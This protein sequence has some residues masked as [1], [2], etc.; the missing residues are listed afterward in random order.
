MISMISIR[1]WNMLEKH[2]KFGRRNERNKFRD[3]SSWK[4][5]V[6]ERRYNWRNQRVSIK[7]FVYN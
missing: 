6:F 7:G 2:G 1:G 5:N 3:V 4:V